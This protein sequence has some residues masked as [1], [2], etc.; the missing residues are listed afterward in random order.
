MGEPL[1]PNVC[2]DTGMNPKRL[3]ALRRELFQIISEAY[4][5]HT[6]ESGRVVEAAEAVLA[7]LDQLEVALEEAGS[8]R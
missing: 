8:V 4:S 5:A 7:D 6:F 2:G 1:P 3:K